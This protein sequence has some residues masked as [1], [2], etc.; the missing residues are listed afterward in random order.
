MNNT[1]RSMG[2]FET[3]RGR[4]TSIGEEKVHLA[5]QIPDTDGSLVV[6][7]EQT[8][9]DATLL[10]V[11]ALLEDEV[12]QRVGGRYEHD[13]DR[14]VFRWGFEKGYMVMA[15]KKVPI[16][17]PR[18]R[19]DKGEET[20]ERY[21]RL[22]SGDGMT[23]RVFRHVIAGIS[24]RDYEGVV[25]SLLDGYGVSKSSVSR[26]W[27]QATQAELSHMMERRLE[28]LDLAGIML[29]GVG[30][31]DILLVV[32]LGVDRGGR[33]H[34]LGLWQGDTENAEVCKGLL[35]DLIQRGLDPSG[36][37]LF[38]VDGAKALTSAIRDIFG[39]SAQIQRCLQHKR[40]NVLSYLPQFSRR[41]ISRRLSAA[42]N[43]KG[44]KKA[45]EAILSLA[46]ELEKI[47]PEAAASL[48]EGL[49]ETLTLHRLA[50][51]H[52]LRVSLRTTNLIESCF[53]LVRA[54]CK[55]VKRWRSP[56]MVR[57]WAGSSLLQA[58]QR[59]VRVKGYDD[60]PYLVS[61]LGDPSFNARAADAES[62]QSPIDRK[63]A[64]A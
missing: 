23:E 1:P 10:F 25:D 57:R 49:E 45:K 13:A 59:M 31:K 62:P 35:N 5:L 3:V 34:V 29:D 4:V 18:I 22:Q 44:Y 7:V 33:K 17:K 53:S 16:I 24:T 6:A 28:Q 38:T 20:L 47:C 27:I 46:M 42:W 30:F 37:Y 26:Q 63:E 58:E 61:A 39:E 54:F 50:V 9:A 15:G 41:S 48:R 21:T 11:S 55:N 51:P 32:A 52:A 14:E 64:A 40:Q 43:M 36:R 2:W 8:A 19:S 60:I 56:H 12:N